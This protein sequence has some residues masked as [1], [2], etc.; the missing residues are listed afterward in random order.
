MDEEL[1]KMLVKGVIKQS[2]SLWSFP[3]VLLKKKHKTY[4]FCVNF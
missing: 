4:R 2:D 1:D 3:S